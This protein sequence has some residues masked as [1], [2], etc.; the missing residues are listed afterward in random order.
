MTPMVAWPR[1]QENSGSL[2]SRLVRLNQFLQIHPRSTRSPVAPALG[3]PLGGWITDNYSWRLIFF[4][5]I[6]IDFLQ[7]SA[8]I[9]CSNR[10]ALGEPIAIRL[11]ART[12]EPNE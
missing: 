11:S 12:G 8:E 9:I 1:T 6:P 4:I 10:Q 5:N 3:P 2:A 7:P